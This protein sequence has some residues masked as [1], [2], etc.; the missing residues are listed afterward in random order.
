MRF[1]LAVATHRKVRL[2]G[3]RG[4]QFQRMPIIRSRHFGTIPFDESGPLGGGFGGEA[5]LHGFKARRQVREPD[6]IP[7]LRGEFG[8]GHPA[9]RTANRSNAE[10]LPCYSRTTEPDNTDRHGLFG[11]SLH[12]TGTDVKHVPRR[13]PS[14]PAAISTFNP[15]A[16]CGSFPATEKH[17]RET[18][19]ARFEII[20]RDEEPQN[21][22][23]LPGG[24]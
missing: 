22:A 1:V 6:V 12:Q 4:Q 3:E 24:G 5:E 20:N 10:T 14:W 17:Y 13:R 16:L 11:C 18:R 15:P 8:L 23:G 19:L 21:R 9:R 7:V 2:M